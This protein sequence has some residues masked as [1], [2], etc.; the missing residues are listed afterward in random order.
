MS[1]RIHSSGQTKSIATDPHPADNAGISFEKTLGNI[2]RLQQ[3]ELEAFITKLDTQ[4]QKLSQTL[5]VRDLTVFR[6][7]IKK[8]LRSTL[9]LSRN[10]QEEACWDPRGHAKVMSKVTKI[11]YALEELG[12]KILDKNSKQMDILALIDQ[13]RGLIIDLLA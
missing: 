11:D 7:M 4:A 9:G 10:M 6:E 8:F 13:L 5:S 3:K 2:Q 12:R 1:M